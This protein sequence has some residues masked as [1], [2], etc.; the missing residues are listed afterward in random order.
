MLAARV[1]AGA[2]EGLHAAHELAGADGTPLHVVH[3][4]VSPDNIYVTYDGAVRIV[5]FGVASAVGR[6]HHTETGVVKGKFAYMAP[7]Q[8]TRSRSVDRRADIWSLGVVLWEFAALRPLFQ[9]D[10]QGETVYAVLSDPIPPPS[11]VRSG[12][13]VGLD[14]IILRAL[15]RDPDRRFQTARELSQ[16]LSELIVESGRTIEMGELGEWVETLCAADKVKKERLLALARQPG[17]ALARLEPAGARVG[18]EVRTVAT[19]RGVRASF[20][21][22]QAAQRHTSPSAPRSLAWRKRWV[23]LTLIVAIA[24]IAIVVLRRH[25]SS[26]P[27]VTATEPASFEELRVTFAFDDPRRPYLAAAGVHEGTCTECPTWVRDGHTGGALSF[28]GVRQHLRVSDD[29][30]FQTTSG[31]TVSCWVRLRTHQTWSRTAFFTKPLGGAGQV[32]NSWA[33]AIEQD[34]Q[35]F[36]Y[37]SNREGSHFLRGTMLDVGR[38]THIAGTWDG[39]TKRLYV[40]GV[41]VARADARIEFSTDSL[42]L[43]GDVDDVFLAGMDGWLDDARVW[44]RALAPAELAGLARGR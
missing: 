29:G 39:L 20:A 19:V 16:S 33:L 9:R 4:D 41:E 27:V 5:D 31:F 17:G 23:V 43:G 2:A 36:F 40:D 38:W 1:V 44:G 24:G 18:S 3:R 12:V 10:A 21:D 42:V 32:G 28:D 8:L 15:E 35:L 26:M 11:S 37:T 22:D 25:D 14:A 34:G 30:A 7:E 13:P 6:I